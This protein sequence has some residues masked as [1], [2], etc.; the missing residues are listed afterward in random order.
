M[1]FKK[2]YI[3]YLE[4]SILKGGDLI[5]NLEVT[6]STFIYYIHDNALGSTDVTNDTDKTFNF[7]E[8]NIQN[9]TYELFSSILNNCVNNN[10]KFA[11]WF[12]R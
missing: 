6:K 3:K 8:Y 4:K 1:E 10:I 9:I 7:E 2:Q 5:C 12:F 11:R